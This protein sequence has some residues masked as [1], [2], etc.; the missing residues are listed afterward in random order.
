[1]S[2]KNREILVGF[3]NT[4]LLLAAGTWQ[5]VKAQDLPKINCS[6][7]LSSGTTYRVRQQEEFQQT[8]VALSGKFEVIQTHK[9]AKGTCFQATL[10]IENYDISAVRIQVMGK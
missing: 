10:R 9:C 6:S 8:G 5:A 2:I 1:M 3:L 7:K 4:I